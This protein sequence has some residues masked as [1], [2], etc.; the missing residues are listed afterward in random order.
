MKNIEYSLLY[1]EYRNQVVEYKAH[2]D[3]IIK[4]K[5][6][7]EK[8]WKYKKEYPET[9]KEWAEKL[10]SDRKKVANLKHLIRATKSK[11]RKSQY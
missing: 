8:L 11:M 7:M 10:S 9:W 4:T 1:K 2:N 5:F 3:R 6:E